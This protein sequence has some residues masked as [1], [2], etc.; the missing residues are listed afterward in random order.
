MIN[1]TGIMNSARKAS[2]TIA[3]LALLAVAGCS[4][5]Q[6]AN[7]TGDVV[8]GV[9]K[10]TVHVVAGAGRLVGRGVGAAYDAVTDE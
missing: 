2:L 6:V 5:S 1:S 4:T 8:G 9:A 10:G 7:T 3:A